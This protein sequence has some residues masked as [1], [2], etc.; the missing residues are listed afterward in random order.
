M[1][2]LKIK[3]SSLPAGTPVDTD[4]VPFVNLQGTPVTQ[5]ATRA[6]LKGAV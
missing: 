2:D 1:A 4:I 5:K 3:I 6:D